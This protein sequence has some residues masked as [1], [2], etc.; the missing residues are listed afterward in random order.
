MADLFVAY[1]NFFDSATLA[2]GSWEGTLP[3]ANLQKQQPST[4]ARTTNDAEASS[5]LTI[6]LGAKDAAV[7]T[8]EDPPEKR[9]W[10]QFEG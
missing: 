1:D 6:N 3:L 7:H 10:E 8:E 5:I 9:A 2:G 4:V